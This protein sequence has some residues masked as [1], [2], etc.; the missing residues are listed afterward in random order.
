MIFFISNIFG[1]STDPV[2]VRETH[3]ERSATQDGG[4]AAGPTRSLESG[5]NCDALERFVDL[6]YE[7]MSANDSILLEWF[8]IW[9]SPEKH[10]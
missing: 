2:F 9:N 5:S 3:Q 4:L 6:F 8:S 7:I 10:M 1:D